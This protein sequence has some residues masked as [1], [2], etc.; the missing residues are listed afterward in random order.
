[1]L[2]KIPNEV[3]SFTENSEQFLKEMKAAGDAQSRET[4]KNIMQCLGDEYCESYEDCIAWARRKFEDYFHDRIVQLTFTFPKDSRTSTGA[5]FWSPPKRFPT[6]IA[7][8]KVDEGATS[9]IR[10]LANLRA[11]TFGIS[12]PDYFNDLGRIGEIASNVAVRIDRRLD[13]QNPILISPSP[14]SCADIGVR[15]QGGRPNRNRP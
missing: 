8:S 5:P 10:A 11:E 12:K 3:N 4:L 9:L 7:F 14:L 15:S 13:W 1:M 6:A 2:E